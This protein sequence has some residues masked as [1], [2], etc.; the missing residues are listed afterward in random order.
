MS[1]RRRGSG[2]A[3]RPRARL[4]PVRLGR[5]PV[6]GSAGSGVA[7][8]ASP[9]RPRLPGRPAAPGCGSL[10][11][12]GGCARGAR[13]GA[14][15]RAAAARPWPALARRPADAAGTDAAIAD[16]RPLG[17][18]VEQRE[19]ELEAQSAG[20][21]ARRVDARRAD[22]RRGSAAIRAGVGAPTDPP[23]EPESGAPRR[24]GRGTR[25][26]SRPRSSSA[27]R[28]G[29]PGRGVA[30]RRARRRSR[31]RPRRRRGRGARG[32]ASSSM[33]SPADDRTWSSID[34]ASR[35]PPAASRAIRCD[36]RRVGLAA[37]GRE[38]PAELAVDL[39]RRSG[40]GRRTAGGATGSPAGTPGGG[41]R[42]T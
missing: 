19:L 9:V 7:V 10:L 8:A 2:G 3:W 26:R 25:A 41:S 33:R 5:A 40:G 38:D 20:A 31:R 39:G 36:G 11:A 30:G 4:R 14:P 16:R 24:P 21:D 17:R 29:D 28:I 42:R 12:G 35:I 6:G 27:S 18:R 15:A 1:R 23:I 34:S 13:A 32:R 22:G 37:V